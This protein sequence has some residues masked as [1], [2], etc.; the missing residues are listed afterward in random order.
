MPRDYYQPSKYA[1]HQSP[2]DVPMKTDPTRLERLLDDAL[3]DMA[4]TNLELF[5]AAGRNKPRPV[6]WNQLA[7]NIQTLTDIEV[8]GEWLR[9]KYG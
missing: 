7:F 9:T 8:S 6:S 3:S 1:Y 2:N 5:V 4:H